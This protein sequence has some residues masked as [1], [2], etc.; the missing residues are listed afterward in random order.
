MIK[1]IFA[2]LLGLAAACSAHA[3]DLKVQI[4]NPGYRC[5]LSRYLHD[6]LW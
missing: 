2:A 5:Y 6:Y 1:T 4:Y 3:A